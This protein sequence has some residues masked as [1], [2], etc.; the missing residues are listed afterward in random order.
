MNSPGCG[1]PLFHCGCFRKRAPPFPA[2]RHR[3]GRDGPDVHLRHGLCT[4]Q[5]SSVLPVLRVSRFAFNNGEG[6][7]LVPN[8]RG[9][10]FLPRAFPC[11]LSGYALQTAGTAASTCIVNTVPG[12]VA[13]DLVDCIECNE[14]IGAPPSM[15]RAATAVSLQHQM[16]AE[17]QARICLAGPSGQA[18]PPGCISPSS[19]TFAV[20]SLVSAG[21]VKDF[22]NGGCKCDTSKGAPRLVL[23]AAAPAPNAAAQSVPCGS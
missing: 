21:W 12:C 4:M 2:C 6:W 10:L 3:S 15:R 18:G 17:P 19:N 11:P 7:L 1:W 5:R 16:G 13:F 23:N 20:C 8:Y 9:R 14:P 22:A